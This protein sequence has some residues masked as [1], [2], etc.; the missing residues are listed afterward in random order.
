[1]TTD[2]SPQACRRA[3]WAAAQGPGAGYALGPASV[4]ALDPTPSAIAF[5]KYV[6]LA[7]IGTSPE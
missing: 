1:M 6:P 2:L 5:M 4:P 7:L 3:K